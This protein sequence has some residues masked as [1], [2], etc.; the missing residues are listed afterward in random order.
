MQ[1]F[2]PAIKYTGSINYSFIAARGSLSSEYQTVLLCT[3]MPDG[4]HL[5]IQ[6]NIHTP[7]EP[8]VARPEKEL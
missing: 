3:I 2:C 7:F 1:C 4:L 5:H 6:I 8:I